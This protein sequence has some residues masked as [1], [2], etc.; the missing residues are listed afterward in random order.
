MLSCLK[1]RSQV[2]EE[3]ELDWH[4]GRRYE[5]LRPLGLLKRPDIHGQPIGRL[6][7]GIAVL[8]LAF[9]CQELPDKEDEALLAYVAWTQRTHWIA[10]W[11]VVECPGYQPAMSRKSYGMCWEVGGRYM[12]LGLPVVREG[13][14]MESDEIGSL[15]RGEEVLLLELG[16]V[17]VN[18]HP[19]LRGR[20]RSDM[21]QIGWITVELPGN[22]PLLDPVNLLSVLDDQGLRGLLTSCACGPA[23]CSGERVTATGGTERVY[24]VGCKYRVLKRVPLREDLDPGQ[25]PFCVL[26][27]DHLVLVK[28]VQELE[29]PDALTR[30]QL[31]VEVIDRKG[32][33]FAS[34]WLTPLTKH[35]EALID[36]RDHLE[37]EKVAR[38]LGLLLEE[39]SHSHHQEISLEV[40]HESPTAKTEDEPSRRRSSQH[41][42]APHLVSL[43]IP[44]TSTSLGVQVDPSDGRSLLIE[45]VLD[46]GDIPEYNA[47]NWEKRVRA[48]DRIF[49]V[50]G[51]FGSPEAL[52]AELRSGKPFHKIRLQRQL[53]THERTSPKK[54]VPPGYP[55]GP[56]VMPEKVQGLKVQG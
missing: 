40:M 17:L 18:G 49:E 55:P 3:E 1:G 42:K 16:L 30:N 19:R 52:I 2:E 9:C 25:K 48:G 27:T 39:T 4:V 15:Y 21:G 8:I 22:P 36:R 47:A 50:N 28:E 7:P 38:E 54:V 20:V 14:A 24:E 33:H 53:D 43:D 31:H 23:V 35:G 6:D 29:R 10:G 44:H 13:V 41:N 5:V 45:A 46:K 37:F 56:R 12:V 32:G 11:A 34:G 26:Q 51:A